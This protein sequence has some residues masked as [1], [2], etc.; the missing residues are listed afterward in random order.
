MI[1][2]APQM[3]GVAVNRHEHLVEVPTPVAKAAH[4][5]HPLAADIASTLGRRLAE[6]EGFE[7][8]L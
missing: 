8:N 1:D 2:S 4:G 7:P 6:R 5:A 3:V